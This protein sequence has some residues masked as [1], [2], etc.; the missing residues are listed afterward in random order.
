MSFQNNIF[1]EINI[2]YHYS[3]VIFFLNDTIHFLFHITNQQFRILFGVFQ[4]IKI[5]FRTTSYN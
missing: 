4:S 3:L 5:K 1:E 2:F